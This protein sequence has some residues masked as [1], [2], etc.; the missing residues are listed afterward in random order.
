VHTNHRQL[1]G[2]VLLNTEV[3][4]EGHDFAITDKNEIL[5]DSNC[6]EEGLRKLQEGDIVR[7]IKPLLVQQDGELLIVFREQ[8]FGVN[9]SLDLVP[10]N[11]D[12]HEYSA[13]TED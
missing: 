2:L 6:G 3:L 5:F 7:F 12:T 8:T 9:D 10:I 13:P 1:S 11:P 4:N